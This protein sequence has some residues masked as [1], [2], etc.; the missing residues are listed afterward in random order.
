MTD[1]VFVGLIITM[2]VTASY[3]NDNDNKNLPLEKKISQTD[4]LV[5]KA[6]SIKKFNSKQLEKILSGIEKKYSNSGFSAVFN[7]KST[8]KAMELTDTASGRVLFKHPGMMR[9]EYEKP[10]KQQIITDGQTLWIYR[11]EDNQ[12]IIGNAVNYFGSGSGASFL[13]DIK[14][15]KKEFKVTLEENYSDKLWLLQL[16][17]FKKNPDL[18]KIYLAIS[19]KTFTVL[20]VTTFN[21]YG[22]ETQIVFSDIQFNDNNNGIKNSLFQFKVPVNCEVLHLENSP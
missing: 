22:D 9:W 8:L 15:V 16:Q 7:Q 3:G 13:T 21:T 19:K 5:Q 1:I 17:P 6:T 11:P 4:D 12:T 2:S 18:T 20:D 10:E 14:N